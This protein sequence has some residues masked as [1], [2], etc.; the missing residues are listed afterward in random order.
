[1]GR[2][3]AYRLYCEERLQ[4]RSTLPKRRTMVVT[5][6]AKIVPVKPNDAWSTDFMADQLADGSKFAL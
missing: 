2:N 6:V 4:L 3:Q 1:M 5:R